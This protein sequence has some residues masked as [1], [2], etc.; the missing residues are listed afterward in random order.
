MDFFH[1]TEG[2]PFFHLTEGTPSFH[3][4]SAID[5][6]HSTQAVGCEQKI[7]TL[8]FFTHNHQGH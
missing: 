5:S 8:L 6:F 2:T 4:T 1:L 7:S 3:Y